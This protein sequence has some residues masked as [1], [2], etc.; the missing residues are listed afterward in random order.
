MNTTTIDTLGARTKD[1][2]GSWLGLAGQ[3]CVVTGAGS[4]IGAAI[5]GA[6]AAEGAA[7]ALLDRNADACRR[8]AD[9]LTAQG[10]R[11]L[12]V[13]CDI[14]SEA[15]V[16]AAA[17]TVD[18]Q[19]GPCAALVNNAGL[20][21][22]AS[23]EDVSVAEWDSVLAVNLTGYLL[24]SRVF[25]RRMLAAGRGSIVHIAS[26]A[27]LHPQTGSG[28]Y[29]ASKGA[30]LLLSRQMAAEWG[31]ARRAQQCDL[32][33]NDPHRAVGQVSMKSRASRRDAPPSRPA[34][35][36]VSPTTSPTRPCTWPASARPTST[37]PRSCRRRHG[38]HVDGP[39]AAP[40]LQRRPPRRL[41]PR[42][43]HTH[44][45]ETRMNNN[46][47]L[48]QRI[49]CDLLVIGSGAGGLS[50]AITA[51][52]HGLDVVVIEKE[53]VFGGTTAF[54]GGVLWIPGN[55]HAKRN[56]VKD[57]REAARRYLQG[58]TGAFFDAE[59]IDTF[60][61]TAPEMVEFSSARQPCSSCPRSTPTTTPMPRAASTWAAPFLRRPSTSARWART[62]HACGRRSRPS[63]SSA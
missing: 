30:V 33:R 40:R 23:L 8:V 31:P 18:E 27:A 58:E 7:V 17:A 19:L 35:A 9:A 24:C 29:S 43:P 14:A 13:E 45:K 53:A 32:P 26:I 61:D 5:A 39:G 55:P 44:S 51:K 62:W 48:P 3:V 41:T 49:E 21:R 10:H 60:L 36:W 28:S 2:S 12:A 52:K 63:P 11:A 15:S 20:L 16:I 54:S 1:S 42:T 59:T 50:T 22:A 6:F 34:V 57:S 56:G 25:G 4:G 47:T 37:A 38:L 46:T